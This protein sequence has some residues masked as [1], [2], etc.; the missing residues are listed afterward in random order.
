MLHKATIMDVEQDKALAMTDSGEFIRLRVRSGM[1]PGREIEWTEQDRIREFP[2]LAPF[3]TAIGSFA[4]IAIIAVLLAQFLYR[5]NQDVRTVAWVDLDVN[6]S[7]RLELDA[8]TLVRGAEAL[9]DDATGILSQLSLSGMTLEDAVAAILEAYAAGSGDAT[10]RHVLLASAVSGEGM[11]EREFGERAESLALQLEEIAKSERILSL[12]YAPEVVEADMDVLAA[13]KKNG[14]SISREMAYEKTGAG[15]TPDRFRTAAVVDIAGA[16]APETAAVAAGGTGETSGVTAG[17][18]TSPETVAPSGPDGR[19]GE[20][21]ESTQPGASDSTAADARQ[22]AHD[23]GAASP[24]ATGGSTPG[25][26]RDGTAHQEDSEHRGET[27]TAGATPPSTSPKPTVSPSPESD[28]K[29]APT[30]TAKPTAKPTPAPTAKP[31]AVVKATVAA[32]AGSDRVTLSWNRVSGSGFKYYKVVLSKD[33]STPAY[34][35]NGYL[36]AI[37]DISRTSCEVKA[38]EDYNGGDF[39]GRVEAGETYYA[40]ITAVYEDSKVAG[41]VVRI[42]IP[43]GASDEA[44]DDEDSADDASDDHVDDDHA[45]PDQTLAVKAASV[46][47]GVKLAW[48]GLTGD[49]F[50]YYKVVVSQSNSHPSYPDD[51]YYVYLTDIGQ[52][53]FFISDPQGYQGGDFGGTLISGQTYWFSITAVF[54]DRK[55]IGN[56]VQV[57]WP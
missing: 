19:Q 43:A 39:D 4:A 46:E 8:R 49:S 2:N 52:T 44:E 48:N 20:T 40:S 5:A 15:E 7:I 22:G 53:R 17:S 24:D 21:R 10:G 3:I 16:L 9:N 23:E 37:S 11:T 51:G 35:E 6:P 33:D 45:T 57:T 38:G 50:H 36:E 31:A 47:G 26:T 32:K 54:D 56:A 28:D 42:T 27:A 13:A 12:G 30:A 1:A 34:P 18:D 25:T 41:N 29:P 55:I 14:L